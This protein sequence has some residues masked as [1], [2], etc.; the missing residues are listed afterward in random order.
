M[1]ARR[2]LRRRSSS[3]R[4]TSPGR[5]VAVIDVLR[6]S[7]TIAVAL[8]QRR[9][10]RHPVRQLRRGGH[11]ARSA[12]ARRRA[13]R[14][15]AA[16]CC[17]SRAST[18]ATRRASSRARRWR[19]RPILLTT[20]N[21]T[22][23]AARRCRA[24]V[25]WSSRRTSTS[26]RCCAMLRAALA[27][28]HRHRDRLRRPGAAVRARGCG[29]RRTLRAP[30][31]PKRLP[32]VETERRR[33]RGACSSTGSM[34]TTSTKL[35]QTRRHGR[36]SPRPDSGTISPSCAAVDSVPRRPDLPGP[37]DHQARARA[38][39]LSAACGSSQLKR[40]LARHRAACCSRSSSAA[41]SPCSRRRPAAR[42]ACDVPR[43]AS[44]RS[45]PDLALSARRVLRLAGRRCSLP[46]APAVHALRLFGR[47]ESRDRPLVDGLPRRRRRAAARSPSALAHERARRREPT[48]WRDCGALRRL[49]PARMVRRRRRVD[50]A[51]ARRQRAH[52]GDARA[53]IRSACWSAARARAR[54]RRRRRR[55][56]APRR[57]PDA[58]TSAAGRRSR[59]RRSRARAVA[60]G[61]ARARSV[62]AGRSAR[63]TRTPED[64]A[65][66]RS[67][68]ARGKKQEPTQRPRRARS[69]RRSR[70]R[71]ATRELSSDELPPPDLLDA[72]AAAQRRRW[73]A[74]A[75]RDGR[76][77]HGR[78]AH[79]PGRGRARRAHDRSRRHAVRGRAGAGR[80]GAADREPRRTT[81]RSR[82]A[83]RASASSRRFPGRARSAS[84]CRTRRRRWWRSA[85]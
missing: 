27:R 48:R 78:A 13:A 36:R 59:G 72:A 79:V 39:A 47:L 2:L 81:S 54:R 34:A 28:R 32:S 26:R 82:C 31:S 63:P 5:V 14:R 57:E 61:D 38:G 53:G 60:G 45:A 85:S 6:A 55:G 71:R 77:A 51:R 49:L 73:E 75:R 64:A 62:A 4:P 46:L 80:E 42:A 15:R 1:R 52:G 12:R 35:F 56:G 76:E 70:R 22:R 67:G 19:A 74:R 33:A 84:R 50:R 65:I 83:R 10:E 16:R 30:A 58:Q 43:A 41:R 21:G 20:T 17:R 23:R 9:A 40:E 3:R 24:R 29:L 66:E 44:A 18:S 25:T 11:A 8:A 37:P 7:T 69:R 68:E